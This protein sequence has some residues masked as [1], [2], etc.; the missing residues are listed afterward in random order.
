MSLTVRP[1]DLPGVVE[2]TPRRF[3]DERGWFAETWNRTRFAD[4]GLD[5]DW[6]QDNQSMSVEPGTLRGLHYQAPPFAQA[7]LV[8]VLAG[9]VRDVVA[10]VRAGSPTY[11]K[12][13]AIELTAEAGNQLLVPVG[14]L[15]GFLTLVPNTTVHYKVDAPY[16]AAHDGAVSWNDPA[17]G[18]DWDLGRDGLP[19]RPILS[20]KD[21]AAPSLADTELLFRY[22]G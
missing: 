3:G 9:A 12:H 13:V 11:G 16:S 17:L 1:L 5:R 15:H 10:D 20:G 8:R 4:A 6:C 21:A 22:E 14:C 18:I 19:D 2:V 7:K